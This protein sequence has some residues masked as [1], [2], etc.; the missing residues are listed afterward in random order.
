M[1]LEEDKTAPLLHSRV[2]SDLSSGSGY[3]HVRFGYLEL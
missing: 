3:D 2:P 1:E